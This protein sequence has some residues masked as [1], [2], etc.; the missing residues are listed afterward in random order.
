MHQLLHAAG[1]R[2]LAGTGICYDQPLLPE[3]PPEPKAAADDLVALR[4]AWFAGQY[5]DYS[6]AALRL[7]P[8]LRRLDPASMTAAAN[9]LALV[10]DRPVT[11]G[12]KTILQAVADGE[13]DLAGRDGGQD[14][15]PALIDYINHHYSEDL[16]IAQLADIFSLSPNYLSSLFKK[17]KQMKFIDYLTDLRIERAKSLL[18]S[19]NLTVKEISRQVGYHSQ[20]HFNAVFCEKVGCTPVEFKRSESGS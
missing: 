12:E 18:R 16:S 10:L 4:D 3:L 8:E 13:Q 6:S 17:E 9:F 14:R 19:T 1:R 11:P 2:V 7:R 20:S 15:I 5:Y